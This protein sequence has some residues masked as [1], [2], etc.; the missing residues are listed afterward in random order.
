MGAASQT[1]MTKAAAHGRRQRP[2]VVAGYFPLEALPSSVSLYV[3]L[4][5]LHKW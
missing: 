3:M 4:M 2:T 1:L 5:V